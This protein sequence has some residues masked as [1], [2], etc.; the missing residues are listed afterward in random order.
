MYK[1]NKINLFS[2][3]PN[4]IIGEILQFV[5]YPK[6][7]FNFILLSKE[8]YNFFNSNNVYNR[9][10]NTQFYI[11]RDIK[12]INYFVVK[13]VIYDVKNIFL[14][15]FINLKDLNVYESDALTDK[16]FENLI[17]LKKLNIIWGNKLTIK[18]IQHLIKLEELRIY[19]C[20]NITD[21]AFK[22]FIKLQKLHIV[23]CNNL[24]NKSIQYLINLEDL[25]FDNCKNITDKAFEKLTKL[26]TINYRSY[27]P[28]K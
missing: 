7:I 12:K 19:A 17:N 25:R 8:F 6:T 21:E 5:D 13:L 4:E 10:Y 26:K 16:T 27:L 15:K 24:T 9:C 28:P 3:I 22:N 20:K 18:S 14:N 11:L 23:S 2:Q 1:K